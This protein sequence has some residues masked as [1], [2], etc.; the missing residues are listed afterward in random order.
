MILAVTHFVPHDIIGSTDTPKSSDHR[1]KGIYARPNPFLMLDHN[2]TLY[3]RP[4]EDWHHSPIPRVFVWVA[5]LAYHRLQVPHDVPL[6][7][8]PGRLTTPPFH[9]PPPLPPCSHI[10]FELPY[11]R[12]AVGA[13][14]THQDCSET[15]VKAGR[16]EMIR[17]TE[18]K[19]GSPR[20]GDPQDLRQTTVT[21][22]LGRIVAFA[23]RMLKLM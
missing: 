7:I 20:D 11:R 4:C 17:K 22:S 23:A 1:K 15:G 5:D 21:L 6:P 19:L 16:R 3:V 12:T 18:V 8:C 2:T 14:L 13:L 10:V 9:L